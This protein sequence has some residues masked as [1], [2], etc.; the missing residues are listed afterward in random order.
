MLCLV[1]DFNTL[2]HVQQALEITDTTRHDIV[3]MTVQISY[4]ADAGYVS[5]AGEFSLLW[6]LNIPCFGE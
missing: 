3:V 6:Q 4:G 5:R 2:G 1:R